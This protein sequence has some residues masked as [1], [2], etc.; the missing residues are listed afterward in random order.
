L[1]IKLENAPSIR[2]AIVASGLNWGVRLGALTA[3]TGEVVT[4]KAVI[5]ES[6]SKILGVVGG[7]YQPLQNTD[8]FNF[9]EPLVESQQVK[10]ET[11][12][13]LHGGRKIWVLAK[14]NRK[15]IEIVKGDVVERHLLLSNSHDGSMAI[16]VGFTPIRV[17]CA[18]TLGWAHRDKDSRLI[19]VYHYSKAVENL[20]AIQQSINIADQKFQMTAEA[21]Q[22]LAKRSCNKSDLEQLVEVVF[23]PGKIS[24]QRRERPEEKLRP[25]DE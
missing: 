13:S 20:N 22:E 24:R 5:R 6:D 15:E 21:Y 16:R 18:N 19:R 3:D 10:V 14:L 7:T 23:Y 12:G 11:A 17:V 25:Q 1:G 4:H 2:E 8:A 9:F